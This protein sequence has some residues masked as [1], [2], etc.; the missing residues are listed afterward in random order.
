M[1]PDLRELRP[2]C[3]A[4]H[5]QVKGNELMGEEDQN[6]GQALEEPGE[7][8]TERAGHRV[9]P[10]GCPAA[11][12]GRGGRGDTLGVWK[13]ELKGKSNAAFLQVPRSPAS[14]GLG[15]CTSS[16]PCGQDR[17]AKERAVSASEGKEGKVRN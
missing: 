2:S 8:R 12:R 14:L 5:S 3:T 6:P 13:P 4:T 7:T 16:L 1:T 15:G 9:Q 11:A 17:R 10:Q